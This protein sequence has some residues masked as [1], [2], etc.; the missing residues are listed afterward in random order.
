MIC[1]NCGHEIEEGHLI[2]EKCG[3]EV[4][5]VPDFE[6]EIEPQIDNI[7]VDEA[8]SENSTFDT[9]DMGG[10]T[11]PTDKILGLSRNVHKSGS[12]I[13]RI[14]IVAVI[15]I[16][17][18]AG[19]IWAVWSARVSNDLEHQ[20][21][22]VKDKASQGRY[23][24]A[25]SDL[26]N[27][28]VS[29]PDASEILFLEAEYYQ[30]M[31]KT[32]QSVDTLERVISTDGFEIDDIYSAYD[33]LIGLYVSEGNYEKI[34]DLVTQCKYPEIVQAYQNYL[35][36]QPVFSNEPGVYDQT[37]RLKISAN[38]SGTIYYTLDGSVPNESSTRYDAP[39]VL[40]HGEFVVSAVFIN[41]YGLKSD[42]A[43]GSYVITN[44][45]PQEPVINVDSGEY[46]KPVLITAEV[47]EGCTVYYTTDK[48][49]PTEDSVQYID[50]IPMPVDYSNFNFIAVTED[51]LTSEVVVKSYALTFPDG[52]S[53]DQAINT[54][55]TRLVERGI[56]NDMEGHSDRAP[57]HF[58]YKVIS[59]IPIRGQGDYYTIREFY[60]D[61]SGSETPTDT[62]YIVEIYQGSTAILGG[63]AVT[64]FLAIA[65]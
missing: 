21:N 61:G 8:V 14:A 13:R 7:L 58:T 62:T 32:D 38:T 52:I 3:Y 17:L 40:E 37:L 45:V 1:P 53:F 49:I 34:S 26:E 16:A 63:N 12:F 20:L 36:I 19:V 57:G 27:I 24:D 44:D 47:P 41:Q 6:P 2:C 28:Y 4:Q 33:R 43:I 9:S 55:K 35:A 25:I 48:S 5:I 18:I 56:I 30:E 46:H 22:R 15:C 65:F 59:A 31:G 51:G 10:A 60:H 23:E 64:G 11:N 42:V 29:H 54:L 39:I 50:P